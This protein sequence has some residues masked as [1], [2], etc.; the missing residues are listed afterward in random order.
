M[1]LHELSAHELAHGLA[2]REFSAREVADA[3][4]SRLEAVE[5]GVKAFLLTTPE[6]AREE[7]DSVDQARAAGESL[8]PLA[9]V[10]IAHKDLLCTRGVRTTCGSRILESFVP[11][12]D[13]TVVARCRAASSGGFHASSCGR[14][15]RATN[16][17]PGVIPGRQSAISSTAQPGGVSRPL[18]AS[19]S[20]KP[21]AAA[22]LMTSCTV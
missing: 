22:S 2:A 12:Y 9:G 10:P 5:D 13:A 6:A 18:R 14:K 19:S 20:R 3:H 16:P 7:A 8:P 15:A 1:Q 17:I 11:P 4:I 21:V